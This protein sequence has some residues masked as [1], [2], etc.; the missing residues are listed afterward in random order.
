MSTPDRDEFTPLLEAHILRSLTADEEARLLALVSTDPD[1]AAELQAI[2]SL[3]AQFD[4]ERRLQADAFTPARVEEEADE[5]FVRLQRAA[6]AAEGSLRAQMLHGGEIPATR[7]APRWGASR[8]RWALWGVAAAAL[9]ALAV[10]L[11]GP[12][13]GGPALIDRRPDDDVLGT[14]ARIVMRAELS[15]AHPELSWHPV[16]GAS[17]YDAVIEDAEGRALFSRPQERVRSTVWALTTDQV[18]ALRA[19]RDAGGESRLRIV[20]RDGA[21]LAVASSGDL[22]LHVLD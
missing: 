21:G 18:E 11:S 3:H 5:G 12:N 6:A 16:V 4:V 20:A 15:A 17:R 8:R 19:L 22:R 2:D 7:A 13:V 14:T 9:V 1:G 10:F